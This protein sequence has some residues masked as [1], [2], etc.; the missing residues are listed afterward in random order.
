[1]SKKK[2]KVDDGSVLPVCARVHGE[3]SSSNKRKVALRDLLLL[4]RTHPPP[5]ACVPLPPLVWFDLS[6]SFSF[7]RAYHHGYRFVRANSRIAN[8]TVAL[9]S[10]NDDDG[11]NDDDDDEDND[12]DNDD[13]TEHDTKRAYVSC[14]DDRLSRRAMSRGEGTFLRRRCSFE[15]EKRSPARESTRKRVARSRGTEK[16]EKRK[17]GGRT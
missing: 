15:S 4:P 13:D 2:K 10:E 14:N 7:S 6:F 1:M 9:R 5:S 17:R 12:N 11:D 16:K 8:F 3:V